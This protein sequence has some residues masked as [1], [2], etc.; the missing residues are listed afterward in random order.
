MTYYLV[1]TGDNDDRPEETADW[2]AKG[3][4]VILHGE[5]AARPWTVNLDYPAV[6]DEE[7]NWHKFN[8]KGNPI[9]PEE[10]DQDV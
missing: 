5:V 3:L 4:A 6:I 10:V 1:R 9:L 2:I 8:S 7:S